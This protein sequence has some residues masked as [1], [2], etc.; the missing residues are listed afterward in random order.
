MNKKEDIYKITSIVLILDQIIKIIVTHNMKLN[1]S[2]HII[3]NFFSILYVENTGAAFS[4]LEDNT[5]LLIII[6]ALFVV[7]LDRYIKKEEKFTKL[8]I[9][10]LGMIMGGIFGNLIDRILRHSVID[11][12]SF[13]VLK[14]NFPIFNLADIGITVGVGLYILSLILERKTQK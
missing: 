13:T 12:L 7:V 6:S 3:P 4:I 10:S 1:T 9:V 5:I 8:G 11:Y 2:I 14:Y